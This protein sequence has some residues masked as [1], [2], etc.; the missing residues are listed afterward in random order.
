MRTYDDASWHTENDDYPEDLDEQAAGTH[1][2]LYL[3][4]A[5]EAGL[6]SDMH[7]EDNSE[8]VRDLLER[9]ITGR[10]FLFDVCDGKLTEEDLNKEGNQFSRAYYDKHYMDDYMDVL[11]DEDEGP[12]GVEDN[13]D[14]YDALKEILDERFDEWRRRKGK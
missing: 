3:A 14:N 11:G 7:R 10:D 1:I 6:L 4:W 2:G 5:A 12:Y 9:D 13:W 8:S